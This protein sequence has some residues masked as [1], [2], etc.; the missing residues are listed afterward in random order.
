MLKVI[1]FIFYE[2]KKSKVY[3]FSKIYTFKNNFY[4]KKF[5]INLNLC[6]FFNLKSK[7]IYVIFFF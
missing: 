2:L 7:K 1:L 5:K 6:N 4:E 3:V